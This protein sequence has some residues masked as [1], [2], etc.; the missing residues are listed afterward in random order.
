[1]RALVGADGIHRL[2]PLLVESIG[3]VETPEVMR[4]I[5]AAMRPSQTRSPVYHHHRAGLTTA[6]LAGAAT[7]RAHT[8][9]GK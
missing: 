1:M 9:D 5:A 7:V 6:A 8:Y 2:E 4:E 3:G